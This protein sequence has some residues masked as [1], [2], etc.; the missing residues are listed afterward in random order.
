MRGTYPHDANRL[1]AASVIVPIA[2]GIAVAATLLLIRHVA[3]RYRAAPKR[4][5]LRIGIDGRPSK[6]SGP[7]RVLWLA[8]GIIVAVLIVLGVALRLDP[9]QERVQLVLALVFLIL[10]QVAWYAGWLIDRQIELARKMTYRIAPMRTLRVS[11]PL[12]IT[13]AVVVVLAARS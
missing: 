2:Y 6:R 7:K 5:P 4:V 9:P 11:L 12:L 13:I 3:R 1:H 8:P 10:A